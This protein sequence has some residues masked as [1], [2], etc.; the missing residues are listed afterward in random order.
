MTHGMESVADALYGCWLLVAVALPFVT[1]AGLLSHLARPVLARKLDLLA[2]GMAVACFA[3]PVSAVTL[4]LVFRLE[5]ASADY[6]FAAI[7]GVAL[8]VPCGA[9]SAIARWVSLRRARKLDVLV[10]RT[11]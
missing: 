8:A 11:N 3:F 1:G 2:F 7:V 9:A 6:F 10:V 5:V 4:I